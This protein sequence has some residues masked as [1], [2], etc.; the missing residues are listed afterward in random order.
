[1]GCHTSLH[2]Q[3]YAKILA[4]ILIDID[5]VAMQAQI[6]LCFMHSFR[7][8]ACRAQQS[9][10]HV[11]RRTLRSMRRLQEDPLVASCWGIRVSCKEH[12]HTECR[13]AQVTGQA[14]GTTCKA[15]RQQRGFVSEGLNHRHE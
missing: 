5:T 14:A 11:Q 4:R 9:I 8:D 10:P 15:A 2:R 3:G 12:P 7:L 1:M 13:L 6:H